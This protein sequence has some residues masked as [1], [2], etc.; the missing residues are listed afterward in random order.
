MPR[1][2]LQRVTPPLLLVS[3]SVFEKEPI[4]IRYNQNAADIFKYSA[5]LKYNLIAGRKQVVYVWHPNCNLQYFF[6]AKIALH[7]AKTKCLVWHGAFRKW[8]VFEAVQWTRSSCF[9]RYKTL[10]YRLVLIK[11][12]FLSRSLSLFTQILVNTTTCFRASTSE[13]QSCSNAS[14]SSNVTES[15]SCTRPAKPPATR[16][17][18]TEPGRHGKSWSLTIW[19]WTRYKRSQSQGTNVTTDCETWSRQKKARKSRRFQKMKTR[20]LL[21]HSWMI[22]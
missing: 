19:C 1:D 2:K 15:P 13:L 3:Q 21:E 6:S 14:F 22:C 16:N 8:F 17:T 10:G 7:V 12:G 5:G 4:T 11:I 18:S 9:I 20:H